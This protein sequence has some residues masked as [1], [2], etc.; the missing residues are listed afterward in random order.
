MWVQNSRGGGKGTEHQQVQ[1]TEVQ[2]SMRKQAASVH[3]GGQVMAC[4]SPGKLAK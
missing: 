2:Q 4:H 3:T 1:L